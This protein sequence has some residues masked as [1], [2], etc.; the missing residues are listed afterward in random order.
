MF[1]FAGNSFNGENV[2]KCVTE[3]LERC[4][5]IG[6]DVVA[7]TTDME[8]GNRNLSKHLG[9]NT[10]K[11]SKVHNEFSHSSDQTKNM[12]FSLMCHSSPKIYAAIFA[13]RRLPSE[14]Q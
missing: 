8:A 6:T 4:H 2:R 7:F 12:L 3:I 1:L 13:A 5:T 14:N 9:I 10:G 11:L